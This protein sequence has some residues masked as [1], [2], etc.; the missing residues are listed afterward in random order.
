[1]Q[2]GKGKSGMIEVIIIGN[3]GSTRLHQGEKSTVLTIT[4]ASS[5]KSSEGK[6]FTDWVSAKVWGPRAVALAEHVRKGQR[7]LVRGRPQASAY[8]RADGELGAELVVHARD[9]EFLGPKPGDS[10]PTAENPKPRR[11]KQSGE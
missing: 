5:R 4:V 3:T 2:E 7:L 9:V 11:R 1:M 10:P 8:T 6:V